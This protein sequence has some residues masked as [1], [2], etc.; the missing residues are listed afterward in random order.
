MALPQLILIPGRLN[1][2]GLWRHQV[3]ALKDVCRPV[4]ADVTRGRSFAELAAS[5][6]T[7]AEDQFA[8][9]GFSFGG[10]V[11]MDMVRQAPERIRRLALLD[12]TMM[13]D[14]EES[15]AARRKTADMA[16][17][18]TRFHGFS[19]QL[20]GAYL[21]PQNRENMEL[22]AEIRAMTE[23]LGADVFARQT[24]LPRPDNREVLAAL[25]CPV[26]VACGQEDVLTTPESHR[27]MASLIPGANLVMIPDAGH[28]TPLE[29][30]EAVTTA[31]RNWL[32]RA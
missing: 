9:A 18:A 25:A 23:R 30:P 22:V 14:T 4:V 5:V 7:M 12:T 11:A 10:I 8:L 26:L 6:L 27:E 19:D 1:D 20:A 31:L 2:D 13:P 32:S 17:R 15:L 16:E 3:D 21:A 29:Q 28:M 24:R